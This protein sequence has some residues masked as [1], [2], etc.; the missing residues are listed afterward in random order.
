MRAAI[1]HRRPRSRIGDARPQPSGA[2]PDR[3]RHTLRGCPD[4]WFGIGGD[5]PSLTIYP[6]LAKQVLLGLGALAF[7]VVGI[8]MIVLGNVA[9]RVVGILSVLVFGVLWV[10]VL[11]RDGPALVVDRRGITD[12]SSAAPAGF[13]PWSEVTGLGIWESNG[14]RILTVG[15]ADP[16]RCSAARGRS[17]GR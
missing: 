15:V 1:G 7:V 14:Q 11:L 13:V 12:R 10:G 8:L 17:P 3:R 9:L 6:A 2:V 16:T 5:A 4:A